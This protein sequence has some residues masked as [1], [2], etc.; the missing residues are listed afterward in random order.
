M[1]ATDAPK[2]LDKKGRSLKYTWIGRIGEEHL[3][4]ELDTLRV[5]RTL[6]E[7]STFDE[8]R[9]QVGS[10]LEL[11]DVKHDFISDQA[12]PEL[13]LA[14]DFFFAPNTL[15]KRRLIKTLKQLSI[16]SV[17]PSPWRHGLSTSYSLFDGSTP[18]VC[19]VELKKKVALFK[20][21]R[22]GE[23]HVGFNWNGIFQSFPFSKALDATLKLELTDRATS[24]K[25]VKRTLG[26]YPRYVVIAYSLPHDGYCK[27]LAVALF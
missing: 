18:S 22:D 26:F 15:S 24:K 12:R 17:E 7:R 27:K 20:N 1:T 10:V 2:Q 23:N 14:S 8:Q 4:V 21:G 16:S 13:L 6:V 25:T 3:L 5:V 19:V 9:L 11:V